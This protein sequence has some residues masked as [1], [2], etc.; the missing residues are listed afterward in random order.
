LQEHCDQIVRELEEKVRIERDKREK[1]AKSRTSKNE[2]IIKK[3]EDLM[4]K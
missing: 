2:E 1:L 4:I 3:F